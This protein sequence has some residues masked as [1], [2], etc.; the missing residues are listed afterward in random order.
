MLP[1]STSSKIQPTH[2]ERLALIYVRQLTLTQVRYYTGSTARQYDLAERAVALGWARDRVRV[3]DQDQ[4]RSGATAVGRDGFQWLVAE[5]GLG[6]AG[7]VLSLEA[8][9]L[10]RACSDW[11]RLLE[12]RAL[13]HILVID[14][15]GIYDPHDYNDRLLLGFKGA[16]SEAELHWLRQRMHG[17]TLVKAQQGHLR[18]PLPIGLT[19]DPCRQIVLDPDEQAQQAVRLIF[20][21]FERHGSAMA[22]LRHFSAVSPRFPRRCREPGRHGDLAWE[23]PRHGRVLS[24][25]HNPLYAG[26]YVFGRRRHR[27][28]HTADGAATTVRVERVERA[29]WLI[30]RKD[31]HPGYIGWDQFLRNQERL[32]SNRTGQFDSA[33]RP[34]VARE[35]TA[36]LQGIVICG[37][38][39]RRRQVR[40]RADGATPGYD[41]DVAHLHLGINRCQSVWGDGVDAAVATSFLDALWPAHLEISLAALDQVEAHARDAERQWQLQVERA[42]YEADLA[43]RRYVAVTPRNRLVAHSPLSSTRSP[44]AGGADTTRNSTSRSDSLRIRC[45]TSGGISMPSP[46]RTS[47]RSSPYS[48]VAMPESTKK[49]WCAARWWWRISTVCGGIRSW[50]TLRSSPRTR[51]HPSQQSP[52]V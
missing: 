21:L 43:R 11:Y 27:R 13:T 7:A 48:I 17:G 16:M 14:E 33:E 9:R 40:Y 47:T 20:T 22:V 45:D 31:A 51:C 44:C 15:E 34:G 39:G 52:Q 4:A 36:L 41:C 29:D 49:N 23:P 38:C 25:L 5:V 8:S 24:I 50:M 12:I 32:A 2:H 30:V 42:H 28:V 18:F 19:H 37:R 3:V 35:G 6:H 46:L 10:A 26:T 1:G